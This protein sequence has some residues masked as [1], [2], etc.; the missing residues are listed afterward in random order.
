MQLVELINK[1]VKDKRGRTWHFKTCLYLQREEDMY[2]PAEYSE[3][4]EEAS[5]ELK[6]RSGKH[7]RFLSFSGLKANKIYEDTI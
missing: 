1:K 3:Y 2:S 5:V 6:S 4:C 7:T